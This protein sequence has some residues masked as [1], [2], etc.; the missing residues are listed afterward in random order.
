MAKTHTMDTLTPE[1]LRRQEMEIEADLCL[2]SKAVRIVERAHWIKTALHKD[3]T[4][5]EIVADIA[6]RSG[7]SVETIWKV[8]GYNAKQLD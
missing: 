8:I 2:L 4:Q 5:D 1:A 3:K 7:Q 6:T